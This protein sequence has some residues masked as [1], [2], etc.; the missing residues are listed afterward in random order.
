M[1]RINLLP[2]REQEAEV[3][4][5]QEL[6]IAGMAIGLTVIFLGAV[7][8]N[9]SSRL[10][11]L[12]DQLVQLK[13]EIKIINTKAKGVAD[14]KN[15]IKTFNERLKIIDEL[16]KKKTGP[17]R[18]MESLSSATPARLWLTEFKESGGSLSLNGLAIDNHTIAEFLKALSSS[19]YFQNVELIETTQVVEKGGRLKKFV[20]R[21]SL[22]YQLPQEAQQAKKGPGSDKN[23]G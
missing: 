13:S 4:R 9:Q 14:L 6:V 10:S 1:I 17:V 16:S 22:L 21:S 3:G 7:F 5:R 19:P 11:S 23:R 18:V 2:T 20:M 12:E 8:L 15:N